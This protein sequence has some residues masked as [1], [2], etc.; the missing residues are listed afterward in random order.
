VKLVNERGVEAKHANRPAAI[1]ARLS[2]K[3][4]YD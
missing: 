4:K 3:C 2:S 1:S